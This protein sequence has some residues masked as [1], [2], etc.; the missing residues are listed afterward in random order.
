MGFGTSYSRYPSW[1]CGEYLEHVPSQGFTKQTTILVYS[2][3]TFANRLKNAPRTELVISIEHP[4][5]CR[6]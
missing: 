5:C 2:M 6:D 1:R 3:P 4:G